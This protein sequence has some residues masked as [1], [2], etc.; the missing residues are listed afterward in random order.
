MAGRGLALCSLPSLLFC[1]S[2]FTRP[3]QEYTVFL[4]ARG[5]Q[6]RNT[7]SDAVSAD[8]AFPPHGSVIYKNSFSKGHN[9]DL[10]G[11]KK[12]D[13]FSCP[14]LLCRSLSMSVRGLFAQ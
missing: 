14:M 12:K 5:T 4:T 8:S 6:P 11:N 7:K 1:L 2:L 3:D 13:F 9:L 10:F